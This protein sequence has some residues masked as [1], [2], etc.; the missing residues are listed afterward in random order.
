MAVTVLA[1]VSRVVCHFPALAGQSEE[2]HV[3]GVP[4][5]HGSLHKPMR[6]CGGGGNHRKMLTIPQEN[7]CE[8]TMENKG[9]SDCK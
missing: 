6:R 5:E 2:K 4:G 9:Y 7:I 8:E 1:R 3:K